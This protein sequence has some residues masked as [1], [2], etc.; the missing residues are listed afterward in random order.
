M[1]SAEATATTLCL[2]VQIKVQTLEFPL[3]LWISYFKGERGAW[4]CVQFLI[5]ERGDEINQ[6][7]DEY[8]PI[9]HAVLHDV[10]FVERLLAAG[11]DATKT[12]NTQMM[13][14]LHILFLLGKK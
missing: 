10:K 11:A 9:H 2:Y 3:I 6:C 8:Y 14:V 1:V 13:T 5:G 12:T 7:Y 4:Q